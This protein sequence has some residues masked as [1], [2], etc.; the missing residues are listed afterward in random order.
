MRRSDREVTNKEKIKEILGMCKTC[1]LAMTDEGKPYVIP[2]SF[3]YDML[4]RENQ[5]NRLILYFHSAKEGRKLD[6]LHKNN[7]VSFAI[8]CEGEAEYAKEN[9]CN[10]GYYYSSVQGFG[11][12]EFVEDASEKCK[13]LSLLMKHQANLDVTFS[14]EQAQPVCVYKVISDAFTGKQ[15]ARM[16]K[17][18]SGLPGKG[19]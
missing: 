18:Q 15:K 3:G 7:E 19:N 9:P 5:E 12:V 4:E 1:Y 14:L 17:K 13:A 16:Q 11:I 10:S 8:A 6:I 2:L